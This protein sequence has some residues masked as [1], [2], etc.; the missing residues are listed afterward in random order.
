MHLQLTYEELLKKVKEYEEQEKVFRSVIQ[1]I[2]RLYAQVASTQAELEEKNKELEK[3]TAELKEAN[4]KLKELD[5]AKT[6]F[7]SIAS[8]ELRTPLT[9]MKESINIVWDGSAGEL[10][11]DQ[12]DFLETAKRNADRLHRLIN[13]LLDFAKMETGKMEY[14]MEEND[15][16][17]TVAEVI[18]IQK[19]AAQ[20]KGI[21]LK[22]ELS[23]KIGKVKFDADRIYQVITNLTNNCI[24]FTATGGVTI[25]TSIVDGGK[26][27]M[28]KIEDTG[29]GIKSEDIPKLFQKFQ[30]VGTDKYRKPGSTGLGLAICSEIIKAHKGKIWV[31]SEYGK[32]S[33][34]IFTLPI[35]T[36]PGKMAENKR[37]LI[38]DDEPDILKVTLFRVKKAGYE[39]LT[40]TTGKQGLEMAE[41]EMPDLIFLDLGLP[42]MPGEEVCLALKTAENLKKIPVIIFSASSDK[43]KEVHE[44]VKADDYLVKPFET[45]DLLAKIKKFTE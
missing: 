42:E 3:L 44:T 29:V 27:L 18:E 26:N 8:H 36:A 21:Y 15:I 12:K 28:V 24:K 6:N 2:E 32:G 30:Q 14:K 13:D 41:K 25:K 1:H 34:F 19:L 31:E 37:V 39:V 5:K 16:N 38:I 40:A 20:A 43:I 33:T 7:L 10:N 11:E 23:P 22:S 9:A 4:E 35:Q 45:A 17:K